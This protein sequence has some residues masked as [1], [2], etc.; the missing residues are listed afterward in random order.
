MHN[1]T[2]VVRSWNYT[3]TWITMVFPPNIHFRLLPSTS[4]NTRGAPDSREY[5]KQNFL[6]PADKGWF[7]MVF[8]LKLREQL[9]KNVLWHQRF[10]D[11][12]RLSRNTCKREWDTA[13]GSKN[14]SSNREGR[15][16]N[17]NWRGK[18]ASI[19]L[20]G[21][22]VSEKFYVTYASYARILVTYGK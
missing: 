18:D 17:S 21:G 9:Q 8:S 13:G 5:C 12:N 4:R 20:K 10:L 2:L 3:A 19:H 11:Q 7:L 14:V 22:Y 15:K 6:S 16:L 1:T